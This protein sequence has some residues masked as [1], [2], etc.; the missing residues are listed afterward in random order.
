MIDVTMARARRVLEVRRVEERL[1]KIR[2]A[3][4]RPTPSLRESKAHWAGRSPHLAYPCGHDRTEANTYRSGAWTAC[5]TCKLE[6]ARAQYA[7]EKRA[8]WTKTA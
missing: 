8:A 5:R 2:E 1:R 4:P 7:K 6:D 3:R